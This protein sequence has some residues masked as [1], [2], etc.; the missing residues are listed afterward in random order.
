MRT[1]SGHRNQSLQTSS[2]GSGEAWGSLTW[3]G[4]WVYGAQSSALKVAVQMWHWPLWGDPTA[5]R[6]L[7]LCTHLPPLS[8]FPAHAWA[9]EI[10]KSLYWVPDAAATF[11][12]TTALPCRTLKPFLFR[13]QLSDRAPR[14]RQSPAMP[15]PSAQP[16]SHI[17]FVFAHST[18]AWGQAIPTSRCN[19]ANYQMSF[20]GGATLSHWHIL[21]LGDQCCWFLKHM[22]TTKELELFIYSWRYRLYKVE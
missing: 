13:W 7:L 9:A 8:Q 15:A 21:T 2:E 18:K 3:A 5:R 16:H 17:C 22:F 19:T 14:G 6:T 10:F 11:P 4:L 1:T 20:S 12:G